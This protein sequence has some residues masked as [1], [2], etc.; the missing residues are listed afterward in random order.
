MPTAPVK[1]AARLRSMPGGVEQGQTALITQ[2]SQVQI[3]PPLPTKFFAGQRPD[4]RER[5]SGL[6]VGWQHGGSRIRAHRVLDAPSAAERPASAENGMFGKRG[7][8]CVSGPNRNRIEEARRKR[9]EAEEQQ[10]IDAL[11]RWIGHPAVGGVIER[12]R[13]GA[14]TVVMPIAR[15]LTGQ[16]EVIR[17]C[18][19]AYEIAGIEPGWE[20]RR[21]QPWLLTV[22]E[23]NAIERVKA[24]FRGVVQLAVNE[25]DGV[26]LV[27][28]WT[29]D[30]VVVGELLLLDIARDLPPANWPRPYSRRLSARSTSTLPA[31]FTGVAAGSARTTTSAAARGTGQGPWAVAWRHRLA[32]NHDL[33]R[34]RA[35]A[36]RPGPDSSR[37]PVPAARTRCETGRY[38]APPSKS[39]LHEDLKE[40]WA[41]SRGQKPSS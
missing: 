33:R 32:N 16:V 2:R 37:L 1:A 4:R 30:H 41:G 22:S 28:N 8:T 23:M 3:L 17:F 27:P 35:A 19:H 9:F 39:T 29:G 38:R 40:L 11:A 18:W 13:V 15:H 12:R 24:D 21:G 20:L 36:W 6:L 7:G 5:R 34:S 14:K 10:A 25:L 26:G 31:P